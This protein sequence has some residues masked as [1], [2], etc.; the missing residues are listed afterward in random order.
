MSLRP[1]RGS[2]AMTDGGQFS[3]LFSKENAKFAQ[4]FELKYFPYLERGHKWLSYKF[5]KL[6]G[7]ETA[8]A[9]AI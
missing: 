3:E 7:R 5:K 2:L 9:K 4:Y 6:L 8:A 1:S